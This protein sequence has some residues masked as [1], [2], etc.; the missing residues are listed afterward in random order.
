MS[1]CEREKRE[2]DLGVQGFHHRHHACQPLD[3]IARLSGEKENDT[4]RQ[5]ETEHVQLLLLGTA[6][7]GEK[8]LFPHEN[9]AA[10]TTTGESNL[11]SGCIVTQFGRCVLNLG[12]SVGFCKRVKILGC[13]GGK[14]GK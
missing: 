10:E 1:V 11:P 2:I 3:K 8:D 4:G 9:R 6:R 5:R 13:F 12:G 14:R 7:G